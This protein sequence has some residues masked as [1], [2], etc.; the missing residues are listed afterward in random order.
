[1]ERG[2][3]AVIRI[4]LP[5]T[6]PESLLKT[7]GVKL[8]RKTYAGTHHV[9]NLATSR[10]PKPDRSA[11]FEKIDKAVM[12]TAYIPQ[13]H[14]KYV[15]KRMTE[16]PQQNRGR[17]GQLWNEFR[18]QNPDRGRD[19][20]MFVRILEHVASIDTAPQRRL[21]KKWQ[22]HNFGSAP[23]KLSGRSVDRGKLIFE[24][25]TCS[26][27]HTIRGAGPK[28][29]PNLTD[30]TKRFRGSKLLRQIVSPS[31]EIHKEFQTQMILADDGRLRTGLVIEETDDQI[32]LVANLLKPE[33]IETIQKSAIEFRKTAEV[34][35]MPV[36]LLDTFSEK[37]ILDL[38]A[39]IQ[40]RS[41]AG[42]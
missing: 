30:V 24:Q 32:R 29:G 4:S 10:K 22:H 25:A 2:V 15:D 40:S 36:G 5:K 18:T 3:G 34:S 31:A 33:K 37:E 8:I 12:P 16:I 11:L 39:Y 41:D 20:A 17:V 13:Q 27:C 21:I 9:G 38:L 1:M 6:V 19:G 7:G 26:R 28:L 14:Q 23:D 35:T 42:K